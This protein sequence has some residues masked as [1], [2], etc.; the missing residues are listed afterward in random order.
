M[1][2]RKAS[3]VDAV[4][5]TEASAIAKERAQAI[6]EVYLRQS[7]VA[8]ACARLHVGPARFHQLQKQLMR[9]SVAAMEPRPAGRPPKVVAPAQAQLAALE[10]ERQAMQVELGMAQTR[11]EIALVLPRV[12]QPADT[13]AASAPEKKT[14]RRP[15]QRRPRAQRTRS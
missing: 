4:V 7:T 8:Q 2:G 3:A 10:R 14:R 15:S 5:Q 6:Y 9:S 12:L 13:P 1:R 11:A